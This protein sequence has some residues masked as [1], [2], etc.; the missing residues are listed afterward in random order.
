[1]KAL[2]CRNEKAERIVPVGVALYTEDKENVSGGA[3]RKT[4][5]E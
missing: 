4:V 5:A 2:N 3:D 1:M